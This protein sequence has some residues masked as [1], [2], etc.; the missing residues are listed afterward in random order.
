M[1]TDLP[2]YI[3]PESPFGI[4]NEEFNLKGRNSRP[5]KKANHGSRPCSSVMRKLRK[6][7]KPKTTE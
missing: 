5:P 2:V 1:N 4:E 3:D 7:K 6:K